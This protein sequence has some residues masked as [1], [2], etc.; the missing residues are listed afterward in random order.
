[1]T[2]LLTI[3]CLLYAGKLSI[4]DCCRFSQ[5]LKML[6]ML[7]HPDHG[8]LF[9]FTFLIELVQIEKHRFFFLTCHQNVFTSSVSAS[10]KYA[11]C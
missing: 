3:I 9:Q 5:A 6:L 8:F 2:E 10:T 1:M 4:L 7:F 11:S